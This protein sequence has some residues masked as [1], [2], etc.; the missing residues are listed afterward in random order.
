[1]TDYRANDFAHELTRQHGPADRLSLFLS[2]ACADLAPHPINAV[3]LMLSRNIDKMDNDALDNCFQKQD[4]NTRQM[5]YDLTYVNGDNSPENLRR[6]DHT[7]KV[8]LI[9]KEFRR[10]VFYVED[11]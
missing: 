8:R 3:E 1:M 7:S 9:D 11:I 5:V 4:Y 6:P 2:D 10:L